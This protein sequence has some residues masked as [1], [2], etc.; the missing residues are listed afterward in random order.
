MLYTNLGLL[1]PFL[2]KKT[3]LIAVVVIAIALTMLSLTL[4]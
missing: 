3:L 4:L 1:S 2:T